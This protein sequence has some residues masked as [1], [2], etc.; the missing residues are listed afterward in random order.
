MSGNDV[1]EVEGIRVA[2]MAAVVTNKVHIMNDFSFDPRTARG[3][4]GGLNR[5]T[6]TDEVP[7][8]LC[9]KALPNFLA[10]LTSLRVKYPY[11]RTLMSK[12]DVSDAFRNVR[13]ASDPSA[14]LVLYFGR[15]FGSRPK[16]HLWMGRVAGVLGAHVVSGGTRTLQHLVNRRRGAA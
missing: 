10:E 4:Q 5:D 8:R 6:L 1:T 15:C 2:P 7:Q 9:G 11:K 14:K 12:A 3:V 16:T 13:I